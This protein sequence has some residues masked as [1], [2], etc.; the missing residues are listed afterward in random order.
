MK[1]EIPTFKVLNWEFNSDSIEEYDVMPYFLS[2]W[3]EEKNR[4]LK[5]WKLGTKSMP[6][7]FEDIRSFLKKASCHQFESRCEYEIVVTGWPV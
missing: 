6:T 5:T 4:K 2:E 3:E 7:D 1:K